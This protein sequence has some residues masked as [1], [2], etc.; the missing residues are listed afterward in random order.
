VQQTPFFLNHGR[1]AKTPLGILL[2]HRKDISNPASCS[3]AERMQR[4]VARARKITIAAQQRHK[5]YYDK[6]H[7]DAALSVNSEAV[8]ST[9]GLNLKIAGTNKLTPKWIGPFKVLERIGPVAYRLELLDCTRIHDVFHISVLKPYDRDGRTKPGPLPEIINDEEHWE[10]ECILDHRLVQRGHRNVL[11]YLIKYE[12]Y[13]HEPN[14]WQEDV[15]GCELSVKDYWSGK[16]ESERLVVML[17]PQKSHAQVREDWFAN[18]AT[19]YSACICICTA[20]DQ[21]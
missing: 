5:R 2:P 6:T 18:S 21:Q 15:S 1:A 4:I 11:G 10:V 17:T 12:G 20:C 9:A 8:L 16:P 19:Y 3:F 13:G 14:E 7:T